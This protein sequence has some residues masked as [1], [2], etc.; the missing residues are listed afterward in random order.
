MQ[1]V[2]VP[3]H[4]ALPLAPPTPPAERES[5]DATRTKVLP[6]QASPVTPHQL[7]PEAADSPAASTGAAE[8]DHMDPHHT[9]SADQL[10]DL[11][12]DARQGSGASST[13]QDPYSVSAT[14]LESMLSDMVDEDAARI[15]RPRLSS[16][17]VRVFIR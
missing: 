2:K 1:D 12:N 7:Q 5:T 4:G 14:V 17:Y 10:M 8:T 16:P 3:Y 15:L 9:I 13:D 6:T 11:E